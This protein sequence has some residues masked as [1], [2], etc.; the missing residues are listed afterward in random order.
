MTGS[1]SFLVGPCRCDA[2][3]AAQVDT[4]GPG[5]GQPMSIR[6]RRNVVVR[7]N[8]PSMNERAFGL[9]LADC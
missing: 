2:R 7:L 5:S 6:S 1:A 9:R 8:V 3:A 4:G